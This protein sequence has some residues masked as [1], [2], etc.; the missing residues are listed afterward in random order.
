MDKANRFMEVFRELET[1]L[2][3]E[4]ERGDYRE[5]TFMGTL[6][7]IKGKKQNAV[8]ANPRYFDIIQQA[9]Q[10]RNIIVHNQS[11]AEPTDSFLE[12]FQKIVNMITRPKKVQDV[13]VPI[14]SIAKAD[15]DTSVKTV[16]HLM[17]DK[18]FS[19]IPVFAKG[20]L[21]GV[22]TEKSL[23]YY[24]SIP[25]NSEISLKD[26]MADLLAA[27]DLDGNP[28][29]YFRFVDRNMDVFS[30]LKLFQRDFREK[31]KLEMLFVTEHG[32][33]SEKVLGILTLADLEGSI[34]I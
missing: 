33:R 1:Y 3:V 18:G 8:I 4:Y 29:D 11:I 14:A 15:L 5:S 7:R 9:A 6:F 13:M 16:I 19:K 24:L 34:R 30:A 23:Y 20:D 2:R 12:S 25:G 31:N 27:I 32:F 22:F 21:L 17:Q 26:K 28:A 10:L